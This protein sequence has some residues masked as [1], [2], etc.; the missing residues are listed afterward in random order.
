M[1]A[2]R[3]LLALAVA[4]APLLQLA[5]MLPHPVMPEDAAQALAVVAED[6]G[7]WFRIHVIAAA[8]AAMSIVAVLALAGLAR[9]RGRG[10]ATTG[11]VLAVLGGG[12]L[13]IAF[14]AEAQLW[15]LAADPSLDRAAMTE[16]VALEH[17]SPG[18]ALLMAGIPL[19][20]IGSLLV[21][22]GLLR[23][24]AVPRWQPGL[25]VVGLLASLAAAPGSS[26][27]PLLFAP[28][29]LG[30]LALAVSV[31]RVGGREPT[32]VE[33]EPELLPV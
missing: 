23:S 9:R 19:A 1:T 6:P 13:A 33:R 20:G 26:I 25:V 3:A 7:G 16:L 11:A 2:R 21:M 28:A 10:L 29:I 4:A 8:S 24:G 31:L 12:A 14:G 15:S 32:T 30:H 27:G 22:A 17:D 18:L 5:G